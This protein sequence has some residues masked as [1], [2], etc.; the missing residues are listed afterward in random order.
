MIKIDKNIKGL[1][2]LHILACLLLAFSYMIKAIGGLWAYVT[3][4]QY[5]SFGSA[6]F[7]VLICCFPRRISKVYFPIIIFFYFQLLGIAFNNPLPVF[8]SW[9]RLLLFFVLLCA[10]FPVFSSEIIKKTQ[11]IN[12][13][14]MCNIC[15]IIAVISFFCYFLGI[16]LMMG[17]ADEFIEEY[18]GHGGWFSG[19]TNQSMM[20]APIASVGACFALV[21]GFKDRDIPFFLL[22]VCCYGAVLFAASRAAFAGLNLAV[23]FIIYSYIKSNKKNARIFWGGIVILLLSFRVWSGWLVNLENKIDKNNAIY[24]HVIDA[25]NFKYRYRIDEFKQNPILG[26]GFAAVDPKNSSEYM[27]DRGSVEPGSSWLA[28]LSMSG[29][30]GAIC[31]FFIFKDA[32]WSSYRNRNHYSI[33]T[34]SILLFFIVHMMFEGYI[35]AG[36]STL[37]YIL[38]STLGASVNLKNE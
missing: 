25:R 30:V 22:F 10:V 27:A 26:I 18:V 29:I 32:L 38:W 8:R 14:L 3:I 35:F 1:S 5:V 19:I 2:F 11:V 7:C 4:F 23:L 36:G 12:F 20:L 21:K 28:I 34:F 13:L 17:H 9:E 37:C 15:M 24:E 16:N 6:L 33:L 31:M